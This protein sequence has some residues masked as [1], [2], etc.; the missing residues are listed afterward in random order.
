MGSVQTEYKSSP[1]PNP[2]DEKGVVVLIVTDI[3]Q[4][5]AALIE[6]KEKAE[7]AV[8]A[9][10]PEEQSVRSRVVPKWKVRS[11]L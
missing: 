2:D 11:L 7:E 9:V 8:K 1:G 5:Y 3:S 6:L 10:I 4:D